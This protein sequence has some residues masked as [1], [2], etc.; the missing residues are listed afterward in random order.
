MDPLPG[1]RVASHRRGL[2]TRV[3]DYLEFKQ[4]LANPSSRVFTTYGIS[5]VDAEHLLHRLR[6]CPPEQRWNRVADLFCDLGS[7]ACELEVVVK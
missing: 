7:V 2:N 3:S 5:D 4:F 1:R 6:N